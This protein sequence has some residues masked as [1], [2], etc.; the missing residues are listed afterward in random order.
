MGNEAVSQVEP[1]INSLEV[2]FP[3][4]N[5]QRDLFFYTAPVVSFEQNNFGLHHMA[6]NVWE[7]CSELYSYISYVEIKPSERM[8]RKG[9]KNLMIPF[10]LIL[11][12]S[13]ARK[14][15]FMHESYCSVYRVA[16]RKKSSPDKG[17][18]HNGFR[19]VKD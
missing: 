3:F 12:K 16:S 15:I 17:L 9:P 5:I 13:N 8:N 11:S 2:S 6:G 19:L 14:I 10:S 4:E 1:K 18:Q 7:W